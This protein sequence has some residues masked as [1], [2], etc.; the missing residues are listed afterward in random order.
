MV[1]SVRAIGAVK[2]GAV[3]VAASPR[4]ARFRWIDVNAWR[5]VKVYGWPWESDLIMFWPR[6]T[7]P[8]L[9]PSVSDRQ[10]AENVAMAAL[11]VACLVVLGFVGMIRPRK[12]EP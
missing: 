8:A 3:V 9:W 12:Y 1:R 7:H 5:P 11:A 6:E 4:V 10:L 2:A